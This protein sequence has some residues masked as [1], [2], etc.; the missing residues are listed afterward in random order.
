MRSRGGWSWIGCGEAAAAG[1]EGDLGD[2]RIL[3]HCTRELQLRIAE[4]AEWRKGQSSGTGAAGVRAIEA[5]VV[6]T[7]SCV[8]DN[9]SVLSLRVDL[10][11][12]QFDE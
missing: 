2:S 12:S 1:A 11:G 6:S 8:R 3:V 5:S 7:T 10:A 9:E 4:A